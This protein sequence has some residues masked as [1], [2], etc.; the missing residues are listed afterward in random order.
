MQI[1][2]KLIFE[3]VD[4]NISIFGILFLNSVVSKADQIETE[5]A[6]I[7][8]DKLKMFEGIQSASTVQMLIS[9]I[10]KSNVEEQEHKIEFNEVEIDQEAT[11]KVTFNKDGEGFIKTVLIEH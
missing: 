7:F 2:I 9:T 10:E 11:Y 5:E 1:N 3:K 4:R 8:N 6:K